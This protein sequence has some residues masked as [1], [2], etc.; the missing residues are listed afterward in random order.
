MPHTKHDSVLELRDV[1]VLNF[2]QPKS[3]IG[4]KRRKEFKVTNED[5]VA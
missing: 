5:D 1:I 2:A 4:K 3:I